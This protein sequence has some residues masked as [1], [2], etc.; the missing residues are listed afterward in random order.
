MRELD[1]IEQGYALGGINIG[2]STTVITNKKGTFEIRIL[3]I[4]V[5]DPGRMPISVVGCD[6]GCYLDRISLK[7][8]LQFPYTDNNEG[9]NQILASF[10]PIV[11]V[12]HPLTDSFVKESLENAKT[13]VQLTRQSA[14]EYLTHLSEDLNIFKEAV[15]ALRR[16]FLHGQKQHLQSVPEAGSATLKDLA[17]KL[18]KIL[19]EEEKSI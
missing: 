17:N 13:E 1:K 2:N 10:K 5:G 9:R 18:L 14:V 7:V 16:V 8:T 6:Y 11:R 19:E 3:S 12:E 15:Q 4:G